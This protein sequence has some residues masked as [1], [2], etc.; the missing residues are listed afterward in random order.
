EKRQAVITKAVTKGIDRDTSMKDSGVEWIGEIPKHWEENV[1]G[2]FMRLHQGLQIDRSKRFHEPGKNRY[3]YITVKFLNSDDKKSDVEYIEDPRKEV[4]CDEDDILLARTGATGEVITDTKG[5][6]HNNF[7]LINF[8][9]D[10][11][12]KDFLVYFLKDKRLKELLKL[13]AGVTTIP[14]LN[15]GDFLNTSFLLPPK[16]EQKEIIGFLNE[17]LEEIDKVISKVKEQNQKLKEYK[18]TL[19]SKVVTGKIK[20]N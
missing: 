2:R 5:V 14:D 1:F 10:K 17:S 9:Q 13:K 4:M 20:I 15:H 6:F 3:K 8:D 18:K 7:F 16:K 19:I 12:I 11:I